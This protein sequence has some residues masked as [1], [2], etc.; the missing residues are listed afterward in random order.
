MSE[1]LGAFVAV[2][3]CVAVLVYL[4]YCRISG[5]N[6]LAE[7]WDEWTLS[8]MPIARL[9]REFE[10]N[11]SRAD[12]IVSL[13]SI[14]SRIER[15]DN[16]VKSLLRQR[17][18]PA[19]IHL[20]IPHISVREARPYVIP[21][22]LHEIPDLLVH[23]CEDLGPATKLLPTLSR[24]S[25]RTRIFVIDDD[26]IYGVDTIADVNA[27][28]RRFPDEII[29]CSGWR[30][31]EDLTDRTTTVW[32][33]LTGAKYVPVAGSAL[34]KP[35]VADIF[36]GLMGYLVQPRFF[37]LAKTADFAGAPPEARYCDD[38]W[39][40]AHANATKL[41][42]PMRRVSYKPWRD[43]KL[44]NRTALARNFNS[45]RDVERRSNT[46]LLRYFRERWRR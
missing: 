28:S 34:K 23:R 10:G 9:A 6:P 40:S 27:W 13:T 43:A 24:S 39:L 17:V 46:I 7:L 31:P 32:A 1:A 20:N 36:Q 2:S 42:C 35:L 16:T 38:V 26:R 18:R 37:D 45:K 30:V 15:I 19:E 11:S 3:V 44:Y 8:R 14:P 29:C 22:W 4:V 21:A 5:T 41:V 33:A 25:P 12:I